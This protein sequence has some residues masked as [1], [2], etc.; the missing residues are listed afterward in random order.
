MYELNI[1]DK[2]MIFL[3]CKYWD[4][5]VKILNYLEHHK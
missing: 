5:K 2:Y 3:L 1:D 4:K